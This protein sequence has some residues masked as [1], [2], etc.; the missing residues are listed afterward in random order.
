MRISQEFH[1]V[2][3]ELYLLANNK[4]GRGNNRQHNSG[5]IRNMGLDSLKTYHCESLFQQFVGEALYDRLFFG[6]YSTLP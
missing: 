1:L 6:D 2:C 5:N 3:S 4:D